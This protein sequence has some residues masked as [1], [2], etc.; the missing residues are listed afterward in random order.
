M[1]S[2]FCDDAMRIKESELSQPKGNIVF[3]LVVFV[4]L[5]V[6]LKL[7]LR[8]IFKIAGCAEKARKLYGYAYGYLG[9]PNA[10]A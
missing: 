9:A 5:F 3:F 7:C 8:H 1:G 6:P 2:V 4:F 10:R